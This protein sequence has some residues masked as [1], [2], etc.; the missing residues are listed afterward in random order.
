[1]LKPHDQHIPTPLKP[2]RR[3]EALPARSGVRREASIWR[4]DRESWE[5]AELSVFF[6]HFLPS[7]ALTS[8]HPYVNPWGF[9]GHPK[10]WT[11][12]ISIQ[13][14]TGGEKAFSW[15][16]SVVD[17]WFKEIPLQLGVSIEGPQKRYERRV[18][19]YIA[20]DFAWNESNM[21]MVV[22]V[23]FNLLII[24]DDLLIDYLF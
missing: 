16:G 4:Q 21:T 5:S 24:V 15:R 8:I 19:Q 12:H 10:V 20:M 3:F 17:V 23:H 7:D 14:F 9:L 6:L 22:L 11:F 1:M 18:L 2:P 13:R